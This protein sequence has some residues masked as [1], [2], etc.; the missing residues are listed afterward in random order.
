MRLHT[1]QCINC[2]SLSLRH[3]LAYEWYQHCTEYCDITTFKGA[4]NWH[5]DCSNVYLLYLF[6]IK[7]KSM[8][9]RV[10]LVT[11]KLQNHNK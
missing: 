7:K 9:Q 11:Q 5:S 3:L 10:V 1:S 6:L 2:T 8:Q 4:C